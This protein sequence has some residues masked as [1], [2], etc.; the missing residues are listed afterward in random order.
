MKGAVQNCKVFFC[1][2]AM[3]FGTKEAKAP[4]TALFE[5]ACFFG[6]SAHHFFSACLFALQYCIFGIFV[7]CVFAVKRAY[8]QVCD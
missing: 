4:L 1:S 7:A 5:S 6:C 8:V 3:C 2:I